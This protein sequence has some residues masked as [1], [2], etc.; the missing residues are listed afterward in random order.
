ML[1]SSDPVVSSLKKT[2]PKKGEHLSTEMLTLLEK[3]KRRLL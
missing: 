3:D 1:V 2:P